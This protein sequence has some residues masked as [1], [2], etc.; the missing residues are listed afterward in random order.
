MRWLAEAAAQTLLSYVPGGERVQYAVQRRVTRS[1]PLSDDVFRQKATRALEHA[2]AFAKHG[3]PRA[4]AEAELYEFGAGWDLVVQLT[5]HSLGAERQTI[6][7][8]RPHVRLELVSDT[9]RKLDAHRSWLE[10]EAG[11]PV[12]R[13]D[14]R[15]VR[16]VGELRERFGIDYL[17]PWDA[18]D[19]R[20]PGETFDLV[21]STDTLEHIPADDIAQILRECRRLLKRDGIM[22]CR[23]D[24]EDHYR[25]ADAR[26]SRYNFLRFSDRTWRA[27]NPPLH[28]QNRLRY[29]DYVALFRNAGL[30]MVDERVSRPTAA[31]MEAI[32]PLELADRFRRYSLD[33][34]AV[35][36]L[37]LVARPQR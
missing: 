14:P 35:R 12:R 5:L 37:A 1:L 36:G 8:V 13:L 4:L 11:T 26:L 20:L 19:T 9:L 21:T 16:G 17:A 22:S 33:D 18:R 29:P 2:R 30:E 15:P 34:L 10:Q 27:L 7:D 31:D 25:H 23:I 6:V 28:Y 3:P 24:L 32:R